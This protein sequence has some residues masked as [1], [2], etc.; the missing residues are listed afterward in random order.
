MSVAAL[1][2]LSINFSVFNASVQ[3]TSTTERPVRPVEHHDDDDRP[4]MRETTLVS[5]MMT[6]FRALGIGQAAPTATATTGTSTPAASGASTVP[7]SGSTAGTTGTAGT[8]STATATAPASDTLEKAVN[9]FAHALSVMLRR[10]GRGEHS[11]GEHDGERTHGYEGHG[12]RGYNGLVQRLEQLAQSLGAATPA[13][14]ASTPAASG[15]AASTSTDPTNAVPVTT[16]GT[17]ATNANSASTVPGR[18][19]N[20][21][22]SAFSHV[23]SFLQ[24]AASTADS[25]TASTDATANTAAS[26]TD[27]L[28]LFLTTLAQTLNAG[29]QISP[30]GS[31][32]NF[33]V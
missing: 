16:T 32:I 26:A 33:S 23:L 14:S 11:E 21:L 22:L 9:E 12:Q 25:T 18:H 24:P 31:R 8:T 3:P 7:A 13:V 15:A 5:A 4:R 17:P 20:W 10:Q 2:S 29:A 27:K 30:K 19:L 6:A 1:T 28:K